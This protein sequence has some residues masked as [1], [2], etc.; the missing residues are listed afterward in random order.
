MRAKSLRNGIQAGAIEIPKIPIPPEVD[1][2]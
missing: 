1:Q 2:N